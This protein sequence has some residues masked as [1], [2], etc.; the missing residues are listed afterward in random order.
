MLGRTLRS[1]ALA[2]VVGT[3][4]W[5]VAQEPSPVPETVATPTLRVEK[6]EL[7]LGMIQAGRDAVGTF[8]FHNDGQVPVK[9]LSAKPS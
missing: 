1:V 8:V 7:E 5:A 6:T 4:G 3:A 2:A 9:I